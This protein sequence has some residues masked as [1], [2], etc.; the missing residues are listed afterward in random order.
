VAQAGHLRAAFSG[1]HRIQVI[2]QAAVGLAGGQR[3]GQ[4]HLTLGPLAPHRQAGR[5]ED[6]EHGRVLGQRHGRERV[7]LALPGDRHQVLEQQ[8]ADAPA[9]PVIRNRERDLGGAGPVGRLVARHPGELAVQPGEQGRVI[10]AWVAADPPG[11][12]VGV[13]RAEIEETQVRVVRRQ[14]RVHRADGLGV[15]RPGRPDL[16]R[17]AVDEQRVRTGAQ[18]RPGRIVGCHTSSRPRGTIASE[19]VNIRRATIRWPR[20]RRP[21]ARSPATWPRT[22]YHS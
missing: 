14:G 4:Q 17:A 21:P 2:L 18:A 3:E 5:G 20:C 22:L 12:A 16:D 13:E 1:R 19:D 7:Q 11:L 15:A 9:V 8:R 6:G 10:R